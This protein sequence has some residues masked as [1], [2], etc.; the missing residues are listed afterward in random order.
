M[1]TDKESLNKSDLVLGWH[2][3]QNM[4]PKYWDSEK[5]KAGSHKI[6]DLICV[7]ADSIGCHTA[8]VAQS[9]SGKSFFL[10]RLIE[11]I[12][13]RSSA[14]CLVFDPN[15]D[16]CKI[17]KVN[18]SSDLWEPKKKGMLTHEK[19]ENEFSAKWKKIALRVQTQGCDKELCHEKLGISWTSLEMDML[20]EEIPHVMRPGLIHCHDFVK[21]LA[22]IMTLKDSKKSPTDLELLG[23]AKKLFENRKSFI[24][25]QHGEFNFE[26]KNTPNNRRELF[27]II[28]EVEDIPPSQLKTALTPSAFKQTLKDQNIKIPNMHK[29]LVR[30]LMFVDKDVALFYFSKAATFNKIITSRAEDRDD[31]RLNV[32]DLPAIGSRQRLLAVNAILEAEWNKAISAWYVASEKED[33]RVPT[34]IV[35]DE[36]HNLIPASPRNKDE[37]TVRGNFRRIVA[38]GRKYGLF[39]ILVSQR[40]DKLDAQVFSACENKVIMKLSTKSVLSLTQELLGLDDVPQKMI[41]K[42]LEFEQGRALIVGQ[43]TQET[44]HLMYCAARRTVEGG[45]NLDKKYWARPKG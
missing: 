32:I 43:W 34:F 22:Q 4:D 21:K 37:E 24:D 20:A 14:R 38:E 26:I 5:L 31:L 1:S 30:T 18:E 36:A 7:P 39:L 6:D 10:G 40:P 12:I 25:D 35:I 33:T 16:F 27:E 15:G 3:N 23:K 13:L 42:C 41:E 8:I 11:E 19:S 28:H 17:R 45:R 9:G 44:P 2:V 29:E